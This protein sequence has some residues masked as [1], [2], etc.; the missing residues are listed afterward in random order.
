MNPASTTDVHTELN[1]QQSKLKNNMAN[2]IHVNPERSFGGTNGEP[3][4]G[5]SQ[6][7]KGGPGSSPG[8]CQK[9]TLQMVQSTLFLSYI[10]EYYLPIILL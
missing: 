9:P 3:P 8:K 10:W 5:A 7:R 4:S 1:A 2:T 6:L